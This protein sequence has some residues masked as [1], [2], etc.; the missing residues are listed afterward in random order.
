MPVTIYRDP[1]PDQYFGEAETPVED[2]A[3]GLDPVEE[4]ESQAIFG[5]MQWTHDAR[6]LHAELVY[7]GQTNDTPTTGHGS[8]RRVA[9]FVPAQ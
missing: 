4:H 3:P 6:E 1:E 8:Y 7:S 5:A 2:F 9:E